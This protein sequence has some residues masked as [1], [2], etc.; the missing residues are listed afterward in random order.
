MSW[1]S[2]VFLPAVTVLA[3]LA[4]Q[5]ASADPAAQPAATVII[6]NIR[7]PQGQILAALYDE[8]GWGRTSVA[9]ASA[10][11][12]GS[13]ATLR[14]AAPAAGRYGVRLFHDVDGDGKLGANMFGIPTEPFG[15]SNDAPAQFGPP[16]FAAAAFDIGAA[17]AAQTIALR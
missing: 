17:G 14:L 4:P 7:T 12:T 3:A 13:T 8:A 1:R 11:V 15:F 10:P 6:T 9:V 16:A 2:F 5:A